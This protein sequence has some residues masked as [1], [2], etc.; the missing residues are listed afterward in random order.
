MILPPP[1]VHPDRPQSGD[2]IRYQ[3]GYLQVVTVRE[4]ER[5]V[6]V[7]H[8][9]HQGAERDMR[10]VWTWGRWGAMVRGGAK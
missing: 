6:L 7:K 9:D 5:K 10:E 2:R 8:T 1:P 4:G 3:G